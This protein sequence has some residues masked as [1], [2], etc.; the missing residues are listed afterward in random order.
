MTEEQRQRWNK[1]RRE[2]YANSPE[3][4]E[5]HKLA[6]EKWL[7][8]KLKDNPNYFRD[9]MKDWRKKKLKD[10]PNYLSD[11]RKKKQNLFQQITESPEVLAEKFVYYLPGVGWY[12]STL[13]DGDTCWK[14]RA[15]AITATLK[16]LK[17]VKD[18]GR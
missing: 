17:E 8:K 15:E 11:C 13:F 4:R 2:R 16:E 9:Y 12:F 6:Q 7:E 14:T 5:R 18:G 10:N 1:N 3:V